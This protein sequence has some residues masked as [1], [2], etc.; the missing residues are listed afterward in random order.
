MEEESQELLADFFVLY[1]EDLEAFR[2]RG[3]FLLPDG[4]LIYGVAAHYEEKAT[5]HPSYFRYSR[6]INHIYA[7]AEHGF[8]S[9]A[10]LR[11]EFGRR[12]EDSTGYYYQFTGPTTHGA[13]EVSLPL[14]KR[15]G[16]EVEYRHS[17]LDGDLVEFQ[18]NKLSVSL[19]R[20]QLFVLTGV[21]ESSNLPGEIFFSGK[22][23]FY[24]GQLEVKLLKAHLVRLFFGETRG[25]IK[26]SGGVCKY[27]PA[28]NGIRLEAVVRF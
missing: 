13:V 6:D 11:A 15:F 3:D 4:T 5:R 14:P 18:R 1:P 8:L 19:S 25:G 21:W 27:V 23:D 16:V 26:C 10:Y 24:Y 9:G 17:Q 12:W 28:F 7:G 22:K 20:V 2:I